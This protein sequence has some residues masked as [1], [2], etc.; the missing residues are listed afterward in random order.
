[1]G[2]KKKRTEGE[3]LVTNLYSK[4]MIRVRHFDFLVEASIDD[5]IDLV[6]ALSYKL[7]DSPGRPVP[8]IDFQNRDNCLHFSIELLYFRGQAIIEGEVYSKTN[9]VSRISGY[10]GVSGSDT[11]AI[12]AIS[13]IMAV[14]LNLQYISLIALFALVFIVSFIYIVRMITI[15]N[16]LNSYVLLYIKV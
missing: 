12:I 8:S 15:A 4:L 6:T 10:V 14:L 2:G 16:S 7:R 13:I 9:H 5:V 11:V 1:M 3:K